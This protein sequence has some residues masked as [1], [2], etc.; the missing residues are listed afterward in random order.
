[1]D[2][3]EDHGVGRSLEGKVALV[4][5]ASQGGTGRAVAIR[6]AA[7][8]AKVA[9]TAPELEGLEITLAA[10]EDVG[11]TGIVLP[12]DLGDPEGARTTLVADTE[13]AFGPIDVLVNNAAASLFK[14]VEDWT[15]EELDYVQQVNVWAGL[16]MVGQVLPGMRERGQGWILNLTSS[17]AEVPPGPPYGWL[18]KAGYGTYG[19]TKAAINRLTS[20]EA[21]E[22]EGRG[23]AVNALTPQAAIATTEVMASGAVA[24]MGGEGD[25]SWI[26]E[27]VDTMAEAA[28]ALCTGDPA[29]L[30]G[31]IAYSLQLLVELDRPV[32]D[33]TGTRLVEGFQPADLPAQIRRQYGFHVTSGGPDMLSLRRPSTPLPEVIA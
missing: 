23:V 14:P 5:G 25:T 10:I 32:Y 3:G 15:L 18:A 20:I 6:F 9:I 7:E 17:A 21:A 12:A 28:L 8:G 19:V 13:A 26:F 1:V 24:E 33:L 31:R 4:T 16:L 29:E 27:P 2:L 22:N 30:T 11:A